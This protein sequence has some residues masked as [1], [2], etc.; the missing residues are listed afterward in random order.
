M[1][2]LFGPAISTLETSLRLR[3][4]RQ[5]VLAA[6]LANADTPNYKRVDLE[7][8]RLLEQKG[9][10]MLRTHPSHQGGASGGARLV[11]DPRSITP[12]GNGV[13]LQTELIENSRNAGAF[14]QH[15]SVLSR[16]LLLRSVAITGNTS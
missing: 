2:T 12:D 4:A 1:D 8:D 10:R 11:T 6:N 3:V 14:V 7:F 15:S 16:L 13:E 5:G 9:T